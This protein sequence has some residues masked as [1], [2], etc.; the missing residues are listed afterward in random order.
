LTANIYLSSQIVDLLLY[1]I[2]AGRSLLVADFESIAI[3]I[4]GGPQL[5]M[6]VSLPFIES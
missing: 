3:P 2:A 1:H 5:L 6:M 4:A